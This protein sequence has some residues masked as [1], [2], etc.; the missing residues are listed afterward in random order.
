MAFGQAPN[1]PRRKPYRF[2]RR[3]FQGE[4]TERLRGGD[5]FNMLEQGQ[6]SFWLL[7]PRLARIPTPHPSPEASQPVSGRP[8]A[9][10]ALSLKQTSQSNPAPKLVLPVALRLALPAK[11][12]PFV[13]LQTGSYRFLA[14]QHRLSVPEKLHYQV[15]VLARL[16]LSPG[17][18]SPAPLLL[19]QRGPKCDR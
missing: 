9:L 11:Q 7:C 8:R 16:H 13:P 14:F 5:E 17:R 6:L 1:A 12:N 15:E 18:H 3:T 10:P 2:R 19:P 4:H